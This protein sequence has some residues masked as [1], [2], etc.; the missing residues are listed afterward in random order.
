MDIGDNGMNQI[1]LTGRTRLLV[2]ESEDRNQMLF[3]RC[4]LFPGTKASMLVDDVQE[5]CIFT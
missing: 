5:K 1:K 3:A 2:R 4:R